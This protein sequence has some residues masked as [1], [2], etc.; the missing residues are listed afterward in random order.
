MK[1]SNTFDIRVLEELA[2]LESFI[3]KKPI[4]TPEFWS[5]WQEKFGRAYMSRV[6]LRKVIKISKVDYEDYRKAKILLETYDE[7]VKYLEYIKV[8]ALNAKG[9]HPGGMSNM[10]FL[11]ED[12][13]DMD[14]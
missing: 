13:L 10:E 12:D 2:N 8:V 1:K 7:I 3:V 9:I 5:E 14:F 4:N 6:A 11:D